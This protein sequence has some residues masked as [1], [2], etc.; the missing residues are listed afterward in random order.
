[1]N[2]LFVEVFDVVQRRC[3]CYIDMNPTY[4]TV[5]LLFCLYYVYV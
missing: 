5:E 4:A 2:A 3:G 1:M